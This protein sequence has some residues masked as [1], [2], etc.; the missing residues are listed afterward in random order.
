MTTMTQTTAPVT[1]ENTTTELTAQQKNQAFFRNKQRGAMIMDN[2]IAVSFVAIALIAILTAMPTI[3]YKMNLSNFQKQESEIAMAAVSWKKARSNY[4]GVSM[5]ELCT[6]QLVSKSICGD[7][8]GQGTN[9]FGGHWTLTG[10][11]GHFEI[12][13]TLPNIAD[14][15]GRLSDVA[16]TMAP[17]TRKQCASADQCASIKGA[18]TSTLTMIH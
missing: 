9:A 4:K 13:A 6:R 12:T 11:D 8:N 18:G 1:L 16:D 17:N 15:S 10:V 5:K 14:E 3:N 7:N 2:M